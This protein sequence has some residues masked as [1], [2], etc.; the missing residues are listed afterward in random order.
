MDGLE[1]DLQVLC[2]LPGDVKVDN[3]VATNSRTLHT[4]TMSTHFK[5]KTAF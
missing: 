4:L 2:S 3:E 5:T 1:T